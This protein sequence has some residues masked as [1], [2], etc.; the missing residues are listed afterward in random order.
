MNNS[1][2][3]SALFLIQI[4]DYQIIFLIQFWTLQGTSQQKLDTK[5]VFFHIQSA[6]AVQ[7]YMFLCTAWVSNIRVSMR[8]VPH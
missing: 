6:V 3:Y 2:K 1:Y 7:P 4:I 5:I 8:A